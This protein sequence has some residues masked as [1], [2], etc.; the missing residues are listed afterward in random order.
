MS[1][2]GSR[3]RGSFGPTSSPRVAQMWPR[4]F[5]KEISCKPRHLRNGL[6]LFQSN[7]DLSDEVGASARSAVFGGCID[8]VIAELA[9]QPLAARTGG[10][11]NFARGG[12]SSTSEGI[13]RCRRNPSPMTGCPFAIEQMSTSHWGPN[14]PLLH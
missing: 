10:K 1:F 13:S 12:S 3:Q 7:D 14:G 8:D 9:A 4:T 2:A 5:E 6:T 11:L